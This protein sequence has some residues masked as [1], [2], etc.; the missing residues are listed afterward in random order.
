MEQEDDEDDTGGFLGELMYSPEDQGLMDVTSS[1]G[2]KRPQGAGEWIGRFARAYGVDPIRHGA[3]SLEKAW[4]GEYGSVEEMNL[5]ALGVAGT[6]VGSPGVGAGF[7]SGI[8][9]P[10]KAVKNAFGNRVA[11]NFAK[12]VE[13]GASNLAKDFFPTSESVG[14]R[15]VD[16]VS[17]GGRRKLGNVIE[18]HGGEG[19]LAATVEKVGG[20]K[21]KVFDID[22][23][24]VSK[25]RAKGF[26]AE[27]KNFLSMTDKVDSIIMNPPFSEGQAKI[28]ILHAI[29]LLKPGGR[30]AAIVPSADL[31]AK[32]PFARWVR[33]NP[34][35]EVIGETNMTHPTIKGK[36]K[37]VGIIGFVSPRK[38]QWT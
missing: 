23:E 1:P 14:K 38:K 27:T 25:L 37:T 11:T 26:A 31:R 13:K 5:D 10:V 18:P 17:R 30:G 15:M 33:D 34:L 36:T 8:R 7:G 6:V 22:P 3:R 16:F 9:V 19:H 35:V 20:V 12:L 21:P 24:R 32:T 2:E 28:H 4:K 29:N